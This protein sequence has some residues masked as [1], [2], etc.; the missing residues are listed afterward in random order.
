[1]HACAGILEP[2]SSG[3]DA[4]VR[5]GLGK[6]AQD[7][8]F[9][10]PELIGAF[11]GC[12]QKKNWRCSNRM[13]GGSSWPNQW[14]QA[15]STACTLQPIRNTPPP[16]TQGRKLLE[17]E[18]QAN[19][20]EERRTRREVWQSATR[21]ATFSRARHSP[22][23]AGAVLESVYVKPGCRPPHPRIRVD[24]PQLAVERDE[25]IKAD[26]SQ[27]LRK[28][29]CEVRRGNSNTL[30]TKGGAAALLA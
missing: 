1:M 30:G 15:A 20:D 22:R 11:R 5:L 19:E 10:N 26:V 12:V 9:T 29:Y 21:A 3:V 16:P 8:Y 28:F 17:S 24:H 2:V 13:L 18:I 6:Q 23:A 14:A 7:D 27:M 25:R 4:G